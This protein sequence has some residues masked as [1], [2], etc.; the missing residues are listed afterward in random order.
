MTLDQNSFDVLSADQWTPNE[1]ASYVTESWQQAVESIIETGRRLTEAKKRVGHGL[2]LDA[3]KLMP[4]G[5]STARKL[6]QISKHPDLANQDHGTDLPASWRTLAVLAQLPPGEI[7]RRIEAGEI[8][9]ETERSEAEQMA[10]LYQLAHQETLN[11]WNQAVD[12]L[13]AALSYAQDF[14]P[15][16][17]LPDNYVTVTEFRDRLHTLQ[18]ITERWDAQSD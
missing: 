6:M 4:F 18:Q 9:P 10:A 14:T 17:E 15:P 2:W 1:A 16:S 3:V 7:P 5:E 13:T 12:G 8:T 11:H